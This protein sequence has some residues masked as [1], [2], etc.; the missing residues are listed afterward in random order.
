MVSSLVLLAPAGIVRPKHMGA[1]SRLLYSMGVVPESLLKWAV[2]RRLK[3]GPMY[4]DENK[5]K[6]GTHVLDAVGAEVE[7]D[8]L[9][10]KGKPSP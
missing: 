8:A 3:S 9:S 6:S 7:G 1:R 10:G 2:K 5:Q 4:A